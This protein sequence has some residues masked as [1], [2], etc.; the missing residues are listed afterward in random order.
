MKEKPLNIVMVAI[1]APVSPQY[2]WVK[3]KA[4]WNLNKEELSD[5]VI[6]VYLKWIDIYN[7]DFNLF[8]N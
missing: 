4:T 5:S 1:I 8:L 3:A 2:K 7:P 6:L